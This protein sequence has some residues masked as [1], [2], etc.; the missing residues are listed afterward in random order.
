M[1]TS[2][3]PNP[4]DLISIPKRLRGRRIDNLPIPGGICPFLLSVGV[5]T[6]GDLDGKRL[7]Q[8]KG[9]GCGMPSLY[10]IRQVLLRLIY[11]RR[12][13]DWSTS[14]LLPLDPPPPPGAF[15]VPVA[16]HTAP[17]DW[18][19][20]STRLFNVINSMGV[21]RLGDL[22]GLAIDDFLGERNC[23]RKCVSELLGL[24]DGA[25]A[26]GFPVSERQ[27]RNSTPADLIA[28]LDDL[29]GAHLSETL[30]QPLLLRFGAE[31]QPAKGPTRIADQLGMTRSAAAKNLIRAIECL[32]RRGG[33][34]LRFLLT[35]SALG[36]SLGTRPLTSATVAAWFDPAHPPKYCAEFY[37]RLIA[38]LRRGIPVAI[39][40]KSVRTTATEERESLRQDAKTQEP[41]AGAHLSTSLPSITLRGRTG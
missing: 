7:S 23:G 27:I 34:R 3:P 8:F 14:P 38:R 9:P 2:E 37:F 35:K 13:I 29:L 12:H 10:R 18:L 21:T 11:P 20:M 28:L 6:L 39:T 15:S 31:G 33:F 40:Q 26:R 19:F 25:A 22:D 32:R 17:P 4:P 30:R 16:L 1:K 5:R 41:T 36:R 24:L